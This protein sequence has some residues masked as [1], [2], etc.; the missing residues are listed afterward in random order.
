M[1]FGV[2]IPNFGSDYSARTLAEYAQDAERAG[3]DGFFLWD[4]VLAFSPGQMPVVDP[5][6]ALTAIA[7]TT[8][9]IRIGPLVT[10]LPR[11]R[12]T[13]LARETASLDQLS[14]GRLILGVGIGGMPF[15]WEYLGEEPDRRIRGA[16]LDEGLEVVTG[17]WTGLPFS[18]RGE[19]YHVGG[20]PP[21]EDWQAI[22]YP[23]PL[24]RPRPPIWIAGTWPT[25]LPFCRAAG[26]DGVC[27][28]KADGAMS[29]DD[30]RA[31]TNYILE[32]R[33]SDEP[34]DVVIAGATPGNDPSHGAGI[35]SAMEKAGATWWIEG[36]DPWRFG[37][38]GENQWPSEEMRERI[39]DGPPKG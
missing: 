13:K 33:S 4:H 24:Q 6:I 16:M 9:R 37:W 36:I 14:G 26:W 27:P 2:S 1:Q 28:L 25:K 35:V 21:D 31:M 32:H 23:P 10:P 20:L 7:M 22:F 8:D 3:W 34:F 17:L 30:V 12:P 18:Y 29:P 19:H 39:N 11:R 15:E 38:T 5:W